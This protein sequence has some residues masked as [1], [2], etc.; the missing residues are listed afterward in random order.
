MGLQRLIWRNPSDAFLAV[1]VSLI[2]CVGCSKAGERRPVAVISSTPASTRTSPESK[3][4]GA[5][6]NTNTHVRSDDGSHAIPTPTI[7]GGRDIHEREGG[8]M[9]LP[10]LPEFSDLAQSIYRHGIERG[11]DPQAFS[12]IGDGEVAT[13]WFLSSF[14]QSP[15]SYNLGPYPELEKTIDFF[16]ESISRDGQAARAGVNTSRILDPDFAD[17]KVCEQGESPLECEL[18][19]NRPS[20]VIISLGTNQVWAPETFEVEM[21]I[22]IQ[23]LMD[24]GVLPI[25]STKGDNLEGDHE[26]NQIVCE[27][28]QEY[29][30]PLWNFWHAI[31]PLPDHGLQ[32]DGEHLTWGP[33]DFSDPQ[34]MTKAWPIRNLTA[35]QILSLIMDELAP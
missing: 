32:S 31:Q 30:L 17:F 8:W 15:K 22:I 29:E 5:A 1:G 2:L 25:L 26:I 24:A 23:K 9:N 14:T 12:R 3:D 27:L 21:R 10:V 18:R 19:L 16:A 28:A 6:M 20:F 34:V 11:N 33:N 35:L 7:D 4:A 13:H